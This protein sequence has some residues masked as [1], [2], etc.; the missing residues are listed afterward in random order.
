ML[1][2]G[3]NSSAI[4]GAQEKLNSLTGGKMSNEI[5]SLINTLFDSSDEQH[6]KI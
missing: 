3:A 2:A 6:R 1:A 5:N 4:T